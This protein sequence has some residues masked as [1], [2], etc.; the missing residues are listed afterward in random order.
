MASPFAN[1][2]PLDPAF[3]AYMMAQQ[4]QMALQQQAQAQ[5]QA[6]MTRGQRGGY[7]KSRV[8]LESPPRGRGG[9]KSGAGGG[10]GDAGTAKRSPGSTSKAKAKAAAAESAA[11]SKTSPT[12]HPAYR[13]YAPP[14]GAVPDPNSK[15]DL[16]T[17]VVGATARLSPRAYADRVIS[18]RTAKEA[19][20][21]RIRTTN[22]ELGAR[23]MAAVEAVK[24]A[25]RQAKE[26]TRIV[27][28]SSEQSIIEIHQRHQSEKRER[29]RGNRE[30]EGRKAKE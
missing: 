3:V 13:L 27:K 24:E 10:G 18:R 4:Q 5:P 6:K 23:K 22:L 26:R 12:S 25:T 16:L 17:N 8:A 15:W 30:L 21:E 28:A 1:G 11:E 2:V 19:E 9:A 20:E 29:L 14:G 7:S